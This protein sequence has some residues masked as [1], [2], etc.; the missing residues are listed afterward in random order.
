MKYCAQCGGQR[1]H[2]GIAPV[3]LG[4]SAGSR[5]PRRHSKIGSHR[6]PTAVTGGRIGLSG[7]R[8]AGQMDE[9]S[10]TKRA[11]LMALANTPR[12]RSPVGVYL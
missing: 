11:K 3:P 5:E 4:H 9:Y 2:S 8:A 7:P 10:Q 12:A 6:S 1:R